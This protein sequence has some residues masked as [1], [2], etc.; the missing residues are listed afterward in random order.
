VGWT[1]T[2]SRSPHAHEFSH[3]K[4]G[5]AKKLKQKIEDLVLDLDILKEAMKDRPF[6]P[7]M[8]DG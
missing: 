4:P 1:S 3:P 7:R 2:L 8:S 5:R 6:P